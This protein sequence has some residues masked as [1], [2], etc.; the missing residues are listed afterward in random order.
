[1]AVRA[2]ISSSCDESL[3]PCH[4]IESLQED[5]V[6][7]CCTTAVTAQLSVQRTVFR[8]I[9]RRTTVESR[10]ITFPVVGRT[11][12]EVRAVVGCYA[13]PRSSASRLAVMYA[14]RSRRA[15]QPEHARCGCGGSVGL[16]ACRDPCTTKASR[17]P[18]M[19][20]RWVSVAEQG[21]TPV[22]FYGDGSCSGGCSFSRAVH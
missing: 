21:L 16:G 15:A 8:T 22:E 5:E 20:C 17:I 14:S 4:D 6:R 18:F 10:L 7:A 12:V 2:R 11:S 1:M 3:R 13:T 9:G 19:A